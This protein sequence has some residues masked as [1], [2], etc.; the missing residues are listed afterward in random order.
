M[1][2]LPAFAFAGIAAEQGR[3]DIL[4]NNA[5]VIPRRPLLAPTA[6]DRQ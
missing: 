6:T 4:V 1:R 2:K 3:L 5:G